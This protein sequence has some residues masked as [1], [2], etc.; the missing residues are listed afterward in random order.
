MSGNRMD[1]SRRN[2]LKGLAACA[3]AGFS[4][5]KLALASARERDSALLRWGLL[6]DSAKCASHCTA[7]VDACNSEH[8]LH[9]FARPLTDAQWI[10]KVDLADQQT[11]RETSLPMLCQHCED[12]PCVA[13][14]PTGAS[15]VREDGIVLVDKHICIGCRYCMLAC[16]YDARSFI[17]ETLAN[18]KSYSPRGKGTVESCNFCVHRI[19]KGDI[20]ACV[21]ACQGDGNQAMRFGNLNDADSDIARALKAEASMQIRS[22]LNLNTAVRYQNV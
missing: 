17:H 19:D 20:P 2:A 14:C 8:N 22:D 18:Q 5:V 10:R 12:P 13:V 15:F 21:E 9:G 11:G 7:C 16:P 6:I 4:I 1:P 3:A